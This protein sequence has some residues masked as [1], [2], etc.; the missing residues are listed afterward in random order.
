M[1]ALSIA[2]VT[3]SSREIADLTGKRH[4][5]VRADIEKMAEEL[6]LTFQEKVEA[7]DGG[8]PSKVYFLP[9]RE[10]LI[11]VSGYRMDLRARI[12]DRWIE[13]EGVV[14]DPAAALNNPVMLRSIL[15]Q[16]VEKVIALE[17]QV[18]ELRPAHEA[19]LRIS[20]A[21]GSLCITE[22]AKALQMRPKDLFQWLRQN[23]WI[24]RRPGAAH[25]L[26]YQ[27]KTT[28]GLLEHKVTTVLRAD[29]SEKMTEQVRITAKGL[30]KLASLI[31]PAL[32]SVA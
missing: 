25:D 18:S 27:S 31:K 12:I 15:L 13:L 22:A 32:R 2:P 26:G 8:R 9:K 1:N 4:D 16:N 21:D 3:M 30:T 20:T 14:A 24:Y 29:G 19:L 7:S 28:A 23:G 5:N 11:L 6:S 10:T 17:A